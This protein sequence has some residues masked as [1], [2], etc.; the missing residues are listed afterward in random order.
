M[1]RSYAVT[2][3]ESDHAPQSGKLELRA[4]GLSLEGVN[5]HSTESL[6]VPYEELDTIAIAPARERIGGRPTLVIGRPHADLLRIASVAQPGIVS[7]LAD[8]LV[9]FRLGRIGANNRVAV[10]VPI[11]KQKR[12]KVQ[13]LLDEGPPFEPEASGL[14]RHQVFLTDNEVVFV[15]EA[16]PGFSL[17]QLLGDTS[18]LAG[19]AAWRDCLAGAPRV[20]KPFY[21]WAAS[22][23]GVTREIA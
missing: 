8:R 11:R 16:A 20:A 21:S 13:E 22:D 6:F 17:R 12:D 7:E 18:V 2:W 9:A 23:D 1:H 4:G 5:G 10:V 19:A 15:F 14:E 3:T